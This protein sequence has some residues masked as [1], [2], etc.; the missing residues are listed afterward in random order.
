MPA[1]HKNVHARSLSHVHSFLSFH[2]QDEREEKRRNVICNLRPGC[3]LGKV[4]KEEGDR[5]EGGNSCDQKQRAWEREA[6]AAGEGAEGGGRALFLINHARLR[7]WIWGLDLQELSQ[8]I[9]FHWLPEA[10]SLKPGGQRL[11]T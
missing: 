9:N 11:E 5:I 1:G 6:V 3:V 7:G 8:A 2:G 10:W 4:S